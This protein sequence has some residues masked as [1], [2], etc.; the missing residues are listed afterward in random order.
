MFPVYSV[1]D[2]PGCSNGRTPQLQSSKLHSLTG[3]PDPAWDCEAIHQRGQE[4]TLPLILNEAVIEV[5]DTG[6]SVE[7][8]IDDLSHLVDGQLGNQSD[9]SRHWVAWQYGHRDYARVG[10][11]AG[12]DFGWTVEGSL[13]R[14]GAVIADR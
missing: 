9:P 13:N 3:R 6:P 12:D 1:T 10:F 4:L 2:V 5:T 14:R 11:G 8:D 7:P